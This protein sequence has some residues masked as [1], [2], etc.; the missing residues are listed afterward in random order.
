MPKM[1]RTRGTTIIQTGSMIGTVIT[2]PLTALM[3]KSNFMGSWPATFYILGVAGII[4]YALWIVLV[5]ESPET[6]PFISKAEMDYILENDGGFKLKEVIHWFLKSF[7]IAFI[8]YVESIYSIQRNV[9]IDSSYC[10]DVDPFW[11]KL[12]FPN[13]SQFDAYVHEQCSSHAN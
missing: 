6:H 9:Y 10:I 12:G 13:R 8:P 2:L 1:E 5:Y 3:C 4:W 11:S 7:I